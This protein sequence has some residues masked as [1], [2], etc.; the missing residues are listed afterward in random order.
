MM[1]M[2]CTSSSLIDFQCFAMQAPD[3]EPAEGA[4]RINLQE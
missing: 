3:A 1:M 4:L 2:G